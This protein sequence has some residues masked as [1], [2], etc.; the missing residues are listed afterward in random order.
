MS[1]EE[2]QISAVEALRQ[3]RAEL[4][5]E[6]E[7]VEEQVTE[8]ADVRPEE[9]ETEA[10]AEE[11]EP[12]SEPDP[13]PD[14]A[15]SL[16]TIAKAEARSRAKLKEIENR[17]AAREQELVAREAEVARY[18]AVFDELDIDSD[19]AV[20]ALAAVVGKKK[21]PPDEEH[22]KLLERI[23]QLEVKLQVQ[24]EAEDYRVEVAKQVGDI[25]VNK[26]LIAEAKA[27]RQE[28]VDLVL[29]FVQNYY[30]ETGKI[31][32]PSNACS[33]I[34][35]ALTER[36][37]AYYESG[38]VQRTAPQQPGAVRPKSGTTLTNRVTADAPAPATAE[39]GAVYSEAERRKKAVEIARMLRSE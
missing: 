13:E 38:V 1:D 5:G 3:T 15:R 20:D 10:V 19:A 11:S 4:T 23:D 2:T 25:E 8:E 6:G 31:L 36:I 9:G 28:P 21:Q 30:N 17:I 26:L 39:D 37:N 32:N 7:V 18:R 29:A 27:N 22:K 33:M 34:N 35:E 14:V 16:A 12:E 24:R